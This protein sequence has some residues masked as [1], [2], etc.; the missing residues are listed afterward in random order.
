VAIILPTLG[1]LVI[2]QLI[3]WLMLALGVAEVLLACS[4]RQFS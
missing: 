1:T 4:F 2:E 3:G